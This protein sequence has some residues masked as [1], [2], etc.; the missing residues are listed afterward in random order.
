MIR[1]ALL[2]ARIAITETPVCGATMDDSGK[3]TLPPS[4][5]KLCLQWLE[6]HGCVEA[7]ED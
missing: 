6:V 7:R 1:K 3:R 5:A 2:R 4:V